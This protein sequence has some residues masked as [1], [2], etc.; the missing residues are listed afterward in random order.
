[1]FGKQV[2]FATAVYS[3]DDDSVTSAT[4]DSSY[5]N[6]SDSLRSTRSNSPEVAK[7]KF[8]GPL[9]W[10]RGYTPLDSWIPP[11]LSQIPR[12]KGLIGVEPY[13]RFKRKSA[14]EASDPGMLKTLPMQ[15]IIW[16]TR[17]G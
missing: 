12:F 8:E 11:V 9:A 1:M 3:D 13:I 4:S 10:W 5:V 14:V 17:C 2:R 7:H 6:S 16:L 15:N